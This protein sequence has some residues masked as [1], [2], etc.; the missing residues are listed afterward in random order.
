MSKYT[1]EQLQKAIE[2]KGY[3]WPTNKTTPVGIIGVRE[4][5]ELNKFDDELYVISQG[6]C[7]VR[8]YGFPA[9]T[10]P[11]KYWME[12]PMNVHGCG[13]VVP[14]QYINSHCKGKHHGQYD[15]LVQCGLISVYRDK[16][17]DDTF[18]LDPA[19]IEQGTGFGIN[20]HK[21][22]EHSTQVEKWSAACQVYANEPDFDFMMAL[23]MPSLQKFFTYTLL[24]AKDIK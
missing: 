18:D 17:K 22:G 4:S 21:A 24:E 16:D 6:S 8:A 13:I 11:G 2:S 14:G 10:K 12:N 9:T 5:L 1:L 23:V 20:I 3:L 15:A 19:T 7:G